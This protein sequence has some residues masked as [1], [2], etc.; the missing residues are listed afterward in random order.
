MIALV[1]DVSQVKR[2]EESFQKQIVFLENI[3]ME[4]LPQILPGYLWRASNLP[5]AFA[6]AIG[7]TAVI[8]WP[9]PFQSP[10]RRPGF[11]IPGYGLG[12]AYQCRYSDL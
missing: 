11:K 5:T 7:L 1:S 3:L 10:T 4:Y 8:F 2:I 9:I 12:S 6:I